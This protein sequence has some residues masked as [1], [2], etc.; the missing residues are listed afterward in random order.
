[1]L[2]VSYKKIAILLLEDVELLADALVFGRGN[3]YPELLVER[4]ELE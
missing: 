4:L 1:M 2:P 3:G